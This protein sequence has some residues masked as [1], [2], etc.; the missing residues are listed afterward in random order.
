MRSDEFISISISNPPSLRCYFW[1]SLPCPVYLSLRNHVRAGGFL[2]I[3]NDTNS[4]LY[5]Y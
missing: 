5:T 2:I 4:Y 3:Y 1:P